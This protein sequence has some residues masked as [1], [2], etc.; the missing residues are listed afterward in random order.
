MVTPTWNFQAGSTVTRSTNEHCC[1]LDGLCYG[2]D[3]AV[4]VRAVSPEQKLGNWSDVVLLTV[5]PV[6]KVLQQIPEM[7]PGHVSWMDDIDDSGSE[8][9]PAF[10]A[11]S[12]KTSTSSTFGEI[13]CC[14]AYH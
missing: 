4:R 12:M 10:Q 1:S 6:E 5:P 8:A 11:D 13:S 2:T 14:A 9:I 3:Y 7:K